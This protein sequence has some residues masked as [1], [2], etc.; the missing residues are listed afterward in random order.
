MQNAGIRSGGNSPSLLTQAQTELSIL[1][2][3][4]ETLVQQ[5]DIVYGRAD[6]KHASAIE[7]VKPII[8]VRH[9]AETGIPDPQIDTRAGPSLHGRGSVSIVADGGD[10]SDASIRQGLCDKSRERIRGRLCIIVQQPNIIGTVRERIADSNVIA[11]RKAKVF[12]ALKQHNIGVSILYS[13]HRIVGR[14]VVHED[15]GQMMIRAVFQCIKAL[16]RVLPPVP[17]QDDTAYLR[18]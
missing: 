8:C 4:K 6:D 12:S 17:I 5:T 16:D 3:E 14:T 10:R 11:A 2:I 7:R 1:P 9:C 13:G 18:T 15:D